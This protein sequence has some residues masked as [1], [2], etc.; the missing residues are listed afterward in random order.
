MSMFF[1]GMCIHVC[2]EGLCL[3]ICEGLYLGQN[4]V[5]GVT[6]GIRCQILS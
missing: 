6:K 5:K 4:I 1:E 3:F 2:F